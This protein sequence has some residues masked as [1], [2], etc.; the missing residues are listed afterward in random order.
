MNRKLVK[1]SEFY[2]KQ[3]EERAKNVNSMN[4]TRNSCIK[5]QMHAKKLQKA[6]EDCISIHLLSCISAYYFNTYTISFCILLC[7]IHSIYIDS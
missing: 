6:H 7:L 3:K 1:K 5:N 2:G 4:N